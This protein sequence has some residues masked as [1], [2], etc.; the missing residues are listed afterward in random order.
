MNKDIVLKNDT[1]EVVIAHPES[2]NMW[3][4][5]DRLGQI[6]QITLNGNHTFCGREDENPLA[7]SRGFGLSGVFCSQDNFGYDETPVGSYFSNPGI[8]LRK[9]ENNKPYSAEFFY[10]TIP[11]DYSVAEETY[12]VEFK[13]TS[14]PKIGMQLEEIKNIWVDGNSLYIKN[15]LINTGDKTFNL[16]E[17]NHNFLML[18]DVRIDDS[19]S[20]RFNYPVAVNVNWGELETFENIMRVKALDLNKQSVLAFTH[21]H[22][23]IN[24][25]CFTLHSNKTGT[26]VTV[27]DAFKV[28][29]TLCWIAPTCF[30]LETVKNIT[31]CPGGKEEWVRK[32]TFEERT[33]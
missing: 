27:E 9:K 20:V 11:Y 16:E 28:K 25:H 15:T 5:Y 7:G 24:P 33:I 13:M 32:Y 6:K 22:E 23:E 3:S 19:Y 29:R 14:A 1:L 26:E 30:C 21:G 31:L 2:M 18:D 8:G 17:Y 10:E 4:R 12:K